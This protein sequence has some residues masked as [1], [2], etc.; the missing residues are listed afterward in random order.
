[1]TWYAEAVAL[2]SI[3]AEYIVK[4]LVHIFAF[5]GIPDEIVT[6]QEENYTSKLLSELYK[7]LY[8]HQLRTSPYHLLTNGLV[9][10]FN[11]SLKSMLKKATKSEGKY[12]NKMLHHLLFAYQ[13]VPRSFVGFSP[14][15]LLYRQAVNGPF[16]CVEKYLESWKAWRRQC[17]IPYLLN[18]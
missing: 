9:K 8:I 10:R 7:M 12:W 3:D 13:E 15:E 16:G 14:F 1:M 17:G 5:V 11:Q 4:E 18:S 6:D 2:Q